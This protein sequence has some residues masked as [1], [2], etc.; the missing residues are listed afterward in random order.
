MKKITFILSLVSLSLSVIPASA[1]VQN[2]DSNDIVQLPAFRV[3]ASRFTPA[4]QKVEDSLAELRGRAAKP[5][6]VSLEVPAIGNA[7]AV[8]SKAE[9]SADDAKQIM[10]KI[11]L[12]HADRS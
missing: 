2:N 4:E 7:A 11:A 8:K 12:R 10:A 6:A 5:Q 1:A 9:K 3:E